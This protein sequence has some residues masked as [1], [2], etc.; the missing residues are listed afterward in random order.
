[1]TGRSTILRDRPPSLPPVEFRKNR[2]I[3]PEQSIET[4]L[5]PAGLVDTKRLIKLVNATLKSAYKWPSEKDDEH[6]LFWP[7]SWYLSNPDALVD[8]HI[9]R[10]RLFNK[11]DLPRT[12][13]NWVHK[14]T[15]PPEPPSMET[16]SLATKAQDGIENMALA[17]QI[18]RQLMR[19]NQIGHLSLVVRTDELFDQYQNGL[20][21]IKSLPEEFRFIDP[22]RYDIADPSDMLQIRGELG[23]LASKL[24]VAAATRVIRQDTI[25]A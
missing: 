3:Q 11:T 24:T 7:H 19:N 10:N 2:F 15:I 16:M 17:V 4:P 1:M 5:T 9:F 13:H 8:P 12:F 6:H 20:A 14:V 22:K 23:R 21:T 25:A 18:G